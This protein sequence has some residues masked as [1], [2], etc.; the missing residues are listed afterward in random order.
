MYALA[1]VVA[2]TSPSMDIQVSSNFER[3][4]FE[5]SG[6]DAAFVRGKM[7][8]LQQSRSIGLGEAM[9]P[10]RETF[11][12]ERVDQAAVADCIRR[13]KARKRLS[14]RP[15]Q[16]L[17]GGGGAQRTHGDLA[18]PARRRTSP[19]PPRIRRSSP[20]PCRPSPAS[21][22]RCRRAS[23]ACCRTRSAWR[24][25]PTILPPSNASS[26]SVRRTTDGGPGMSTR[27]CALGQRLAR[28]IA[29]H[30]ASGD[31]IARACGW[32]PAPATR[33]SAEHGISHLLEHM[34]FKG[35]ERRSASDIAEEIEAVGG[36][37]NAATSLETT[38][39]FARILKADIGIAL[40]ILADIL[41]HPALCPGRARARARGDPAG[42]RRH[43]RQPRRDRLRA[44]AGRRLSRTR[45]SAGRSSARTQ[46]VARFGAGE[47]RAFLKANYCASRMVLA[48]A[49]KRRSCRADAPR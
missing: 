25:C 49:G 9:L 4:L 31:G 23:L 29:P 26:R 12:A 36:E 22:R 33:A 15:A 7:Q 5:A 43:A 45:R 18:I 46:S 42:D 37:L 40:D 3:F 10:Y 44:A 41:Q 21:G 30:A 16:R 27:T 24:H 28:G 39:Y 35:T 38:A 48:A 6:R 20:T 8:G 1:D 13:V 19:L 34:A 17:R 2:T 32:P 14:A 47:L 11:I